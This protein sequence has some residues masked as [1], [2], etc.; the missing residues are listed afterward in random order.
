MEDGR[1]GEIR[2][3]DLLLPKQALYQAKLHPELQAPS[4]THA[5]IVSTTSKLAD[6]VRA[7]GG[8]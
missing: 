2:T 7:S 6:V 1:G 8:E 3:R 4:H 5:S